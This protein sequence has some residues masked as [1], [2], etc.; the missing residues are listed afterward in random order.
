MANTLL[1]I[2]VEILAV[3]CFAI[4]VAYANFWPRPPRT[5]T[6]PRSAL[7]Q[8]VLRWMHAATWGFLGLAALSLKYFS[9]N[10]AQLLGLLGLA[11]YLVFMAFFLREKLRFPQG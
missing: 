4:A 7:Q 9:L 5:A 2:P 11:S 8:F 10:L 3:I 1:G 6:A